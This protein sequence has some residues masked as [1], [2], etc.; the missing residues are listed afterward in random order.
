MDRPPQN[1][2]SSP[3][4]LHAISRAPSTPAPPVRWSNQAP[5][6]PAAPI[7]AQPRMSSPPRPMPPAPPV[8]WAHP[9]QAHVSS[10]VAQA[11]GHPAVSGNNV[12]VVQELP[13][14]DTLKRG[15]GRWSIGLGATTGVLAG[16]VAAANAWNPIGWGL[17]AGLL[18]AG[19]MALYLGGRKSYSQLPTVVVPAPNLGRLQLAT[20]TYL[21]HGTRWQE[22]DNEWWT[23]SGATPGLRDDEDGG[24]SFTLDP[25]STPKVRNASVI[26]RYQLTQS[27]N[28][29]H[30]RNKSE[31]QDELHRNRELVCYATT[32]QEIKI[33]KGSLARLIQ[34]VDDFEGMGF[35]RV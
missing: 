22:G 16:T 24:V 26:I 18:V 1:G 25:R 34:Y 19:G 10:H 11:K 29:R 12:A 33:K 27:V 4:P 3:V 23:V 21:Y 31:F 35:D 17:G 32:E 8:R 15:A 5:K 13:V 20:G 7:V 30:C 14:W 9:P 2:S 28:A 6:P